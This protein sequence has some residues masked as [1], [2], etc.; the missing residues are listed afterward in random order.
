MSNL[1][2]LFICTNP[3]R[4]DLKKIFIDEK[5]ARG[6]LLRNGDVIVW[7]GEVMHTKVIPFLSENGIHFSLFNDRLSICWQFESWKDIQ[8]RLVKAKHHLEVMG[9]TEEGYIIIDTRYYTHTDMEFPEIHYGDLF[10]DGY[11]LKPLSVKD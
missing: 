2:D 1:D 11:E 5:Y 6:I 3:T 4:R 8:E 9:F 10:Q 7:N